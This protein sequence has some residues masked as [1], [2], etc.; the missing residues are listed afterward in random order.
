MTLSEFIDANVTN[1]VDFARLSGMIQI[2]ESILDNEQVDE[3]SRVM[4][5]NVAFDI[6]NTELRKT[7]G[8]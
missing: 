6:F 5:F 1:A 7:L 8:Q 3:K 2:L 4:I